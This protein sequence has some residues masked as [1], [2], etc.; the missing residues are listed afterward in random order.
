MRAKKTA[1]VDSMGCERC[2]D[3]NAEPRIQRF[4]TLLSLLLSS[5]TKDPITYAA[6][7]RLIQFGCTPEKL[8]VT[9]TATIEKLIYPAGF[10]HKKAEYIKAVAETCIK[11][12]GGDIPQDIPSLCS[13]KGIGPKMA[14]IAMNA[15]WGKPV[16]IG[17]DTHVHRICNTLG[18]VK[19]SSP[20]QTRD[21]LQ[22][23]LPREYWSGLNV[24]LVG[25]GQEICLSRGAK[26][27]ECL[28]RFICPG[29]TAK[30]GKKQYDL[31]NGS[32]NTKEDVNDW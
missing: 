20:E 29:S 7:Q 14:F 30:G 4:Q 15:A 26:C 19:T 31:M 23:W 11:D 3:P 18:W 28:N 12:Y 8:A 25:F 24:A 16:G 10:H 5:Q 1:P 2:A 21:H 32:E 9:D 22:S 13:L 17:V 27:E 6:T